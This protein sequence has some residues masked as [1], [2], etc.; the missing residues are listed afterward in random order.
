MGLLKKPVEDEIEPM[1]KVQVVAFQKE[2]LQ[3]LEEELQG[4]VQKEE[5]KSTEVTPGK[6]EKVKRQR[7]KVSRK[8]L[9]PADLERE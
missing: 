5:F 6:K 8:I 4:D 2:M 9:S 7:T 3:I 1:Q